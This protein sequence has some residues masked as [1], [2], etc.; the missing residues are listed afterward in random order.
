LG[1]K[2]AVVFFLLKSLEHSE[3]L[4]KKLPNLLATIFLFSLNVLHLIIYTK[5]FF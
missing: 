3:T 2:Y 5:G 4:I 1:N